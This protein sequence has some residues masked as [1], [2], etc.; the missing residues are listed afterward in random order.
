MPDLTSLEE[1]LDKISSLSG[2]P[3]PELLEFVKLIRRI[4]STKDHV[5][6]DLDYNGHEWHWTVYQKD[7][8]AIEYVSRVRPHETDI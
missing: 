3:H 1:L 8:T 6:I 5:H 4:S 2:V 7:I